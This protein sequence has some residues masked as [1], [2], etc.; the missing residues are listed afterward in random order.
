MSVEVKP[1]S[2]GREL[3]KFIMYPWQI[4]RGPNGYSNWVPPLIIDQKALFNRKKYPF[5]QHAEEQNFLAFRDGEIVGRISGIVDHQFVQNRGEK[6]A[7]FGFYESIDD[8]EVAREL[9]N[10]VELWARE[11]GMTRILGPISPTPNH[12]LGLL[13]NDFDHPPVVQI[14]YNPPYYLRLYE[15]SGLEKE[16]DHY[17]Y[18]VRRTLPLSDQIKRVAE[19]ARKRGKVTIRPFNMRR[20]DEEVEMVREIYNSAWRNN[21]DFVPWTK[22]EFLYMARDLK[23][24]CIKE[25]VLLA[26]VDGVPAG[27]SISIF[28]VNQILIKMNGRLLPF[29]IFKLLFGKSKIDGFRLANMGIRDEYRNMGID[30]IFVYETY[31]RSEK[32]GLDWAEVSL[33]LE[34]NDKLVHMLEKWGAERYRT[35]RVFQKAL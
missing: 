3:K 30:A 13:M 4:Y 22:E 27:I 25:L 6:T 10:A 9:F 12:I 31:V 35:Y 19:L 18:I 1:V 2:G 21:S 29:G 23:L 26:F 20:F 34:D 7:Y 11:R 32:Y 14:P 8:E 15:G 16:T 28:D 33:I 5:F 17:A 24:V